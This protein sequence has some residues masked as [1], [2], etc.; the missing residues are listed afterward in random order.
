LLGTLGALTGP[1]GSAWAAVDTS[2][3]KCESCPFETGASGSVRVGVG[4]VSGASA[5][6][7]DYTGLERNGAFAIVGG[8][9]RY[10]GADGLFGS[11]TAPDLGLDPRS[12]AAEAG[13]EGLYAL[14]LGY[15]ELPRHF[16]DSA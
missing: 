13:R 16:S 3:W 10:R 4:T 1:V 9:A 8:A 2:Q 7:G 11:L 14:R 6:F 15:A 5:K 12:L